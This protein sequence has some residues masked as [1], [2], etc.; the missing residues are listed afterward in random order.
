M[1]DDY[2]SWHIVSRCA[3]QSGIAMTIRV[4]SF[5]LTDTATRSHWGLHRGF[6]GCPANISAYYCQVAAH[7]RRTPGRV[8]LPHP[9]L[10]SRNQHSV[11][12]GYNS[13]C[14]CTQYGAYAVRAGIEPTNAALALPDRHF[15]AGGPCSPLVKVDYLLVLIQQ[16]RQPIRFLYACVK[17]PVLPGQIISLSLDSSDAHCTNEFHLRAC[18]AALRC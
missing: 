14:V 5:T 11:V 7:D 1:S 9:R 6:G 10:R 3:K 18:G 13:P 15:P 8:P 4:D 2:R 16:C 17:L 12:H